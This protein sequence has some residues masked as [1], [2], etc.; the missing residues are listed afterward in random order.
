MEGGVYVQAFNK[1]TP[2]ASH[3]DGLKT[4]STSF[5]LGT[6]ERPD[7]IEQAFKKFFSDNQ[8]IQIQVAISAIRFPSHNEAAEEGSAVVSVREKNPKELT[9]E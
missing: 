2:K 1:V 9:Y 4:Q 3:P 5:L 6:P 7:K 8:G